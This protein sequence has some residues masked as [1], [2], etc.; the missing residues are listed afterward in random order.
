MAQPAYLFAL[1]EM[2]HRCNRTLIAAL[3]NAMD[4][5]IYGGTTNGPGR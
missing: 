2:L 3:V 5:P 4:T 1:A